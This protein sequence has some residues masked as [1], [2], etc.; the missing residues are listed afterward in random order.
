[1]IYSFDPDLAIKIS[2][3]IISLFV[4]FKGIKEYRKAQKWKKL[5]F[6]SKEIKEFFNDSNVKR[7]LFLLDW[8]SK[9]FDIDILK[10]SREID[11]NFNDEDIIRALKTHNER[12]SFSDKEIAIKRVFDSLF[13]RLT[14]FENYIETGLVTAKD[15]QPYLTYWI[16]IL[17]DS[18]NVRKSEEIRTQLWKYI[19][20]YGYIKVRNLCH[21]KEF[22]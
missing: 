2:T 8:N 3:L 7:A 22:K 15:L 1:M 13:D 12:L 18:N 9:I 4:F 17:T 10:E 11:L 16:R 21:R 6:V 19:D 20:E 5:E 14:M